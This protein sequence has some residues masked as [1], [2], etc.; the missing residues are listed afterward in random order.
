MDVSLKRPLAKCLETAEDAQRRRDL[1][2]AFREA[3]KP[4]LST[5]LAE[6]LRGMVLGRWFEAFRRSSE[7]ISSA[8]SRAIE[9]DQEGRSACTAS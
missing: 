1:I 2:I 5:R 7:G 4:V 3:A 8:A 9:D 6:E